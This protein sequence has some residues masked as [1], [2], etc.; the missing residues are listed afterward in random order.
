MVIA[1]WWHEFSPDIDILLDFWSK[2]WTP[3][4]PAT[5]QALFPRSVR[6]CVYSISHAAKWELT[7]GCHFLPFLQDIFTCQW[8]DI[9]TLLRFSETWHHNSY[10]PFRSMMFPSNCPN[11]LRRNPTLGS[12]WSCCRSA[13]PQFRQWFPAQELNT[14]TVVV[15]FGLAL[16]LAR[17]AGGRVKF[18]SFHK[19]C[20]YCVTSKHQ[21]RSG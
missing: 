7:L 15:K 16:Q 3:G 19:Y 12:Y 13:H 1:K 9:S 14:A 20:V 6:P 18:G 2:D 21:P 17:I 11:L 8:C 10:P 5:A 4:D